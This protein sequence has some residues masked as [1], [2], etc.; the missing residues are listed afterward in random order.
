MLWYRSKTCDMTTNVV[1]SFETNV[2]ISFV[3]WQQMLWYRSR[4][5]WYDN[6][7][8]DIVRKR[9]ETSKTLIWQQM[10]W[11]RVNMTTN[12]VISFYKT[13]VVISFEN[14]LYD[15]KCC[16]IVRKHVIWQQMLWYRSKTCDMK[17]SFENL[18]YDNKCCDMTWPQMLWYRS[19]TCDMT[20]NVVISF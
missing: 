14:M 2:V 9:L 18:L 11:Y 10:L 1:I 12:V 4:K 5:H 6:K 7:C 8:C 3:I 16:D 13:N 19:K 20:T 17:I 15:N